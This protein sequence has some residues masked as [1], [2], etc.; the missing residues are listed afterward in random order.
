MQ[1]SAV[2]QIY[3]ALMGYFQTRHQSVNFVSS[4]IAN[5]DFV[6]NFLAW[7]LEL[8]VVLIVFSLPKIF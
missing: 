7:I 2:I 4:L 6:A 8:K 5:T 3:G 1:P